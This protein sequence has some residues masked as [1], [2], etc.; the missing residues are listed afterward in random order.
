MTRQ[1]Q[2]LPFVEQVR[3][4]V[5]R[6]LALKPMEFADL[7]GA[8]LKLRPCNRGCGIARGDLQTQDHDS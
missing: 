4:A 8:M 7:L 1:E 5:V 3:A 2:S 6:A